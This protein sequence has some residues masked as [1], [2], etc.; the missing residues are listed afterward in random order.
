ME[1]WRKEIYDAQKHKQ[2]GKER[3]VEASVHFTSYGAQ[4]NTGEEEKEDER[5]TEPEEKQKERREKQ[6]VDCRRA[7]GKEKS[8]SDG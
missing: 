6:K 1:G 4:A 3:G 2:T 8:R 7:A 5:R